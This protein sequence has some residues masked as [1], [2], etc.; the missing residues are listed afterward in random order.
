[1]K[2][3]SLAT[4]LALAWAPFAAS[5]DVRY[6]FTA[7][8][9]SASFGETA[10]GSFSIT[11]PTFIT[12]TT[13]IPVAALTS[14]QANSNVGAAWCL[15][16]WMLPTQHEGYDA[17]A[18]GWGSSINLGVHNYY[19]FADGALSAYGTY[20]TLNS[21]G[22]EALLVVSEVGAVPEPATALTLMAGLAGLAALRRRR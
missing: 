19:Y 11:L 14:C 12:A 17:V 8:S 16:P 4:L 2:L 13:I 6:D 10:I 5:A 15:D 7:L 18:F 1:M 9:G 21:P 20:A 3:R 22:Q